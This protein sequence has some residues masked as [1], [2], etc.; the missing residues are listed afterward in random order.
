MQNARAHRRSGALRVA[1]KA[2]ASISDGDVLRIPS[3]HFDKVAADNTGERVPCATRQVVIAGGANLVN[4]L[5]QTLEGGSFEGHTQCVL[6][7]RHERRPCA[8]RQAL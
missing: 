1:A 3:A 4:A 8:I 2:E 5:L 6:V 7:G